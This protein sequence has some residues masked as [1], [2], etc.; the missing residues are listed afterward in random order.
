VGPGGGLS[1]DRGGGLSVGPGGGLNVG[2]GGGLYVGPCDSPY[3]SNIP[4]WPVFVLELEKRGLN[5]VARLIRSLIP[6]LKEMA[7]AI[8]IDFH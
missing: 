5:D 6:H 7:D 2:A 4:P 3:R 8:G 1:V